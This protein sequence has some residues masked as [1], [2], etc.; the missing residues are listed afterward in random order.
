MS[1]NIQGKR[2]QKK[3]YRQYQMIEWGS[4]IRAKDEFISSISPSLCTDIIV[5]SVYTQEFL[6]LTEKKSCHPYS[7]DSS[8]HDQVFVK[9][10]I[11]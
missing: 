8:R 7:F 9:Q 6:K 4:S 3:K 10:A 11:Y 1:K 2:Y 5:K